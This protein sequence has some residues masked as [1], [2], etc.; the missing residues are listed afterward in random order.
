MIWE[1]SSNTWKATS[2][3]EGIFLHQSSSP[4]SWSSLLSHLLASYIWTSVV[5]PLLFPR[6]PSWSFILLSSVIIPNDHMLSPE[7]PSPLVYIIV[8]ND[9]NSGH[10]FDFSLG[11]SSCASYPLTIG[12]LRALSM[13]IFSSFFLALGFLLALRESAISSEQIIL[14]PIYGALALKWSYPALPT[15]TIWILS[16]SPPRMASFH[17]LLLKLH[18]SLKPSFSMCPLHTL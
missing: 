15:S 10:S 8:G 7:T 3:R 13:S 11:S 4:P 18:Q 14:K 6:P 17:F 16:C 1:L 2:E 5:T 12:D 9:C